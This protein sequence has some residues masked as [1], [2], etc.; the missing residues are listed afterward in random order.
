MAQCETTQNEAGGFSIMAE[1]CVDEQ[2]RHGLDRNE[3]DKSQRG[4]EL[5][6]I[7]M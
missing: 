7:M 5:K 3:L 6:C 1:R 2:I 4:E